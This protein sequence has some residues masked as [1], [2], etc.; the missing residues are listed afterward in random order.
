MI[1]ASHTGWPLSELLEMD[2]QELMDW[3]SAV[4]DVQPKG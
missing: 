3:L 1:L 4:K 2:G